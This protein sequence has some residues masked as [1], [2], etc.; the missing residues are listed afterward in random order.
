MTRIERVIRRIPNGHCLLCSSSPSIFLFVENLRNWEKRSSFY[1]YRHTFFFHFYQHGNSPIGYSKGC[2][3][4]KISIAGKQLF[5]SAVPNP[6][7][8][9][10]FLSPT[11][12]S[13]SRDLWSRSWMPIPLET[14]TVRVHLVR[15]P[16][17]IAFCVTHD[18]WQRNEI[19]IHDSLFT[20]HLLRS[21]SASPFSFLSPS[22][23]FPLHTACFLNLF[24]VS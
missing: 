22:L 15:S 5:P 11:E 18:S 7:A 16:H 1:F 20:E 4:K 21:V 13:D 19:K 8:V 2:W 3:R 10:F 23:S 17:K 14:S 24:V 9:R 6:R 12:E